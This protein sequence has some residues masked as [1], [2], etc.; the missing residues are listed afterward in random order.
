MTH[1]G[2]HWA[3]DRP[4]SVHPWHWLGP[5]TPLTLVGYLHTPDTGWVPAHPWHW[6]GTC[7]PLTAV[8]SMETQEEDTW[9]LK[10][11]WVLITLKF[12]RWA[13]HLAK[14]VLGDVD[15]SFPVKHTFCELLSRVFSHGVGGSLCPI[16]WDLLYPGCNR[17]IR[18]KISYSRENSMPEKT[19]I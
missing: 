19:I 4:I 1:P 7:T 2:K 10:V 14:R 17:S 15:S 3:K 9:N 5:C 12:S 13:L 16:G 18:Y 8:L 6:L 11:S